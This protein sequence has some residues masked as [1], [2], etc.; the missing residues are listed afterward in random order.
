MRVWLLQLRDA[1]C[2]SRFAASAGLPE[3]PGKSLFAVSAKDLAVRRSAFA[4]LLTYVGN[5]AELAAADATC[6]FLSGAFARAL[7]GSASLL[8]VSFMHA[9]RGAQARLRAYSSRS[10]GSSA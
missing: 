3:L 9:H 8:E 6:A 7:A 4:A 2:K 10:V 1:L 5:H